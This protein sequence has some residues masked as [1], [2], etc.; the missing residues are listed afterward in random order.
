MEIQL[1]EVPA[2]PETADQILRESDLVERKR[3]V[4]NGIADAEDL[5]YLSS[6]IRKNSGFLSL[7]C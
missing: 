7:F 5:K 2:Q 3:E 6:A 1:H 4:P